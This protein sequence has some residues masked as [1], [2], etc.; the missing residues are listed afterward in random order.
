[1]Q[2]DI[3]VYLSIVPSSSVAVGVFHVT[4]DSLVP[5]EAVYSDLMSGGGHTLS[6]Y[7][8]AFFAG[9]SCCA[10]LQTSIK[11]KYV[12]IDNGKK[13]QLPVINSIKSA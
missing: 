12:Y 13:S 3:F 8:G 1:M 10:P 7:F 2:Y 9:G 4:T 5:S 6:P 11:L